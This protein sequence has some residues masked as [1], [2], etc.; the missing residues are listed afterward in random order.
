MTAEAPKPGSMASRPWSDVSL[1]DFLKDV[2]TLGVEQSLQSYRAAKREAEAL[3][4][5]AF[6]DFG[7]PVD[8]TCPAALLY[9]LDS[10]YSPETELPLGVEE[11]AA[12]ARRLDYKRYA[13]TDTVALPTPPPE[14]G[15]QLE[16]VIRARRSRST[17]SNAPICLA[18]LSI[19]L[20]LGA[21]VTQAG[22]VP[23]RAAPSAGALYAI[24][25]Y[26]WLFSVDGVR[27]GLYHYASLPHMLEFVKPLD[28]WKDLWPLLD[29]G[30]EGATPAVA[31]V[32][33]ARLPRVQTKYGERGYRFAILES[34]H[35][36]QNVLLTA[37]AL[38]LNSLPAGGFFDAGLTH[39][40]EIDGDEEC[41]VYVILTGKP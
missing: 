13:S 27:S 25:V 23:R 8:V 11:G 10:R 12:L 39:L 38:G 40:L 6:A 16:D 2:D 14:V 5:A 28:G 9:H 18:D 3:R 20:A 31:F 29:R 17:F 36:A 37:T 4:R 33:T 15:A 41:A 19:L 35:I 1:F 24:E 34:G 26:P 21:G 32:L 7:L 30:C 22:E